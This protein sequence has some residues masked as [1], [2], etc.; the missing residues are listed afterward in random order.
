[1]KGK[2]DLDILWKAICMVYFVQMLRYETESKFITIGGGL[3]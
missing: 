2:Q 3:S 1:M